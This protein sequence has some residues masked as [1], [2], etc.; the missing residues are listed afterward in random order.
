VAPAYLAMGAGCALLRRFADSLTQDDLPCGLTA[1]GSGRPHVGT[2]T[3]PCE[4]KSML[5]EHVTRSHRRGGRAAFGGTSRHAAETP[6][7]AR[8][9]EAGASSATDVGLFAARSLAVEREG[10]P[11]PGDTHLSFSLLASGGPDFTPVCARQLAV[12]STSAARQSFGIAY[13]M[14][15][16]SGACWPMLHSIKA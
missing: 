3:P 4:H 9:A 15:P 8:M 16:L 12:Q 2:T 1:A 5:W 10:R 6:Y 14:S 7:A 13:G 11:L